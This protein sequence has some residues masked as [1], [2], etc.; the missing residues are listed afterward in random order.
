MQPCAVC[1]E[2]RIRLRTKS[3]TKRGM[4]VSQEVAKRSFRRLTEAK[5]RSCDSDSRARQAKGLQSQQQAWK[6]AKRSLRRPKTESKRCSSCLRLEG[7]VADRKQK[8]MRGMIS[9][10]YSQAVSC[11]V[12]PRKVLVSQKE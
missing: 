2:G 7:I 10:D 9:V 12:S 11:P 1:P 5:K 4:T 8:D 6:I 3:K